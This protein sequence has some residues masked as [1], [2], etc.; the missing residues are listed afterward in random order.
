MTVTQRKTLSHI[1]TCTTPP[2]VAIY[3][4]T[5]EIS[6]LSVAPMMSPQPSKLGEDR[7]QAVDG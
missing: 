6:Q 3:A 2:K 4:S 1:W 7:C 5:K